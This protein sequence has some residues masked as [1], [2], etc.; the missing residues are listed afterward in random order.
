MRSIAMVCVL[1]AMSATVMGLGAG[2]QQ[3]AGTADS[4]WTAPA[5][6]LAKQIVVLSG[7]GPATLSVQNASSIGADQVAPI[8]RLLEADLRAGGVGVRAAAEGAAIPTALRVTLSQNAKQGLWVA[9]VLQG[10]ETRVAMTAVALGAGVDAP[11]AA[12]TMTL[13]K[14]MVFASAE[15]ILD[16]QMVGGGAAGAQAAS[17]GAQLVVLTPARIV[18]YRQSAGQ[19]IGTAAGAWQEAGSFAIAPGTVAATRDPRGVLAVG[20]AGVSAFL[21]GVQCDGAASAGGGLGFACRASDDPWP[22]GAQK[23]FYDSARD[24]LSGVLVPAFS[25]T[26]PPFYSAA[27]VTRASGTATVFADIHGHVRMIDRGAQVE[28]AGSRDWGSD[29]ASVHSGCGAGTQVL[30]DAA[31]D[32]AEDSLRA[33]EMSGHE[34][35][36]VS[37]ALALDGSVT[38]LHASL[39]ASS[40]GGA[41][42]A[43]V[44]AGDQYEV[45]RVA[46]DCH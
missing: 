40:D 27:E 31:G 26:L 24:Y 42:M 7:P 22:I 37:A 34:A 36:A 13:R 17:S 11:V 8:R 12:A 19:H 2:A 16:A 33:Y 20:N 21:P 43:V 29:V 38:A 1:T 4:R 3:A 10:T 28:V 32:P 14:Q 25:G 18:V 9:E 39:E 30:V 45:W 46:L 35:V 23:A 41:A 15:R 5:A 44:L 6:D